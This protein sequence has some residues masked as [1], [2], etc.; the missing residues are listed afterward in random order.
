MKLKKFWSVGGRAPGAPPQKSAT[1]KGPVTPSGDEREREIM[2]L[3]FA[4]ARC[5]QQIQFPENKLEVISFMRSLSLGVN[6]H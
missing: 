3:I 5:E 6:A 4:T 1:A 2:F